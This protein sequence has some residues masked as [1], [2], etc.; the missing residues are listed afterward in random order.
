[1]SEFKGRVSRAIKRQRIKLQTQEISSFGIGRTKL[2]ARSTQLRPTNLDKLLEES[3]DGEDYE[4]L[5]E[6]TTMAGAPRTIDYQYNDPGNSLTNRRALR[7]R[8]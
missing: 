2:R 8:S 5:A 3:G 1:M 4:P 6:E 7:W